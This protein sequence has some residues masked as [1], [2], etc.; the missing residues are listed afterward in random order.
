MGKILEAT[1]NDIQEGQ[2]VKLDYDKIK[3]HPDYN[4]LEEKYKSYIENHKNKITSVV[5]DNK[6]KDHNIVALDNGKYV[7]E[8]R[9]YI[10]DLIVIKDEK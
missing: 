6:Y 10:G 9:F 2:K 8:W 3:S 4:R 5:F 1:S 7:S